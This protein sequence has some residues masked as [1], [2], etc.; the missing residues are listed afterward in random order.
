MP[1]V[2]SGLCVTVEI[3]TLGYSL[4]RSIDRNNAH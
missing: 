1:A 4:G 3:V 2:L